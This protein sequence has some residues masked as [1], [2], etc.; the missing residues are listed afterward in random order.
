M[1]KNETITIDAMTERDRE[2]E[3]RFLGT[4]RVERMEIRIT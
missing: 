3:L 4:K 2:D 1:V